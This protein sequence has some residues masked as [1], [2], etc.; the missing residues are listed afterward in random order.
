M[1]KAETTSDEYVLDIFYISNITTDN[2]AINKK[3]ETFGSNSDLESYVT[4]IEKVNP[5]P[6]Y[7]VAFT[8]NNFNSIL[9]SLDNDVRFRVW[10]H[11]GSRGVKD[12]QNET[13]DYAY[14][15]KEI[16]GFKPVFISREPIRNE[17]L[18][19]TFNCTTITEVFKPG[20]NPAKY[21]SYPVYQ[22]KNLL[23]FNITNIHLNHRFVFLTKLLNRSMFLFYK[24]YDDSDE[25]KEVQIYNLIKTILEPVFPNMQNADANSLLFNDKSTYG[26]KYK[27]DILLPDLNTAIEFKLIKEERDIDKYIDQI[28]IDVTNYRDIKEVYKIF[29][30]V[31]CIVDTILRER[32]RIAWEKKIQAANWILIISTP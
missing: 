26:T 29:I 25:L 21:T 17:L 28:V 30:C 32:V 1:T 7:L 12:E 20:Q 15:L 23:D 8:Q 5:R 16:Y 6:K 3:G 4:K 9:Y 31:F 27:A 14:E 22:K 19:K 24:I 18:L 11:Y 10:F 13:I 2:Q